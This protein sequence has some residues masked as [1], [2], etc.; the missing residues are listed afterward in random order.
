MKKIAY[1]T[2]ITLL[3]LTTEG[4]ANNGLDD[5]GEIK[6]V[7]E[8]AKSSLFQREKIVGC[9]DFAKKKELSCSKEPEEVILNKLPSS[10]QLEETDLD[11]DDAREK[12]KE[13]LSSILAELKK[14]RKE[15]QA[16]RATI[17]QL[18]GIITALSEKK[19]KHSPIRMTKVKKDIKKITPKKSKTSSKTATL[20]RKAIKEISRDEHSA[21]IEVQ[22]NESLSTYAQAYYND[23]SKYH[24]IYNANKDKI[25]ASMVIMIGDR[26]TIPLP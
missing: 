6:I 23:N 14:L 22:N 26:L 3:A 13:Q 5:L 18:K 24:R 7:D 12:M 9:T 15:Q 10:Q 19:T 4:M 16:D 20:I 2:T 1:F 25:P 17:Q 11:D 8:S 21:V